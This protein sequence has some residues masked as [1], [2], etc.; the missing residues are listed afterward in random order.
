MLE[1]GIPETWETEGIPYREIWVVTTW[2]TSFSMGMT[3][4]PG[5]VTHRGI[6]TLFA[7][8][9]YNDASLAYNELRE[10]LLA[11]SEV[12]PPRAVVYNELASLEE[13][14]AGATR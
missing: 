12:D 4:N 5:V 14:L 3:H 6:D 8:R 9:S 10:T 2:R 7:F 13:M 11:G 1:D